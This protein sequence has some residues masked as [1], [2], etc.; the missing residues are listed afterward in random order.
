MTLNAE[1]S[2]IRGRLVWPVEALPI[3]FGT[4]DIRRNHGTSVGL[5]PWTEAD[6]GTSVFWGQTGVPGKRRSGETGG[7]ARGKSKDADHGRVADFRDRFRLHLF[8]CGTERIR[9]R[10]DDGLLPLDLG[11]V[12]GRLPE[13]FKKEQQRNYIAGDALNPSKIL[14]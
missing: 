3:H 11:R 7:I 5:F 10:G 4:G 8:M 2:S 12:C 14:F 13:D 9:R 1:L 6:S